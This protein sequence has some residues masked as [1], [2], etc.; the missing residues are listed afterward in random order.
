M[1]IVS[2]HLLTSPENRDLL[3]E[4]SLNAVRA[5][6]ELADCLDFVVAA[7]PIEAG[8][9]NVYEEWKSRAAMERFRSDGP[10]VDLA[11][12]IDHFNITERELDSD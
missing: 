6:R 2:G 4:R 12:L 3:V 5:A 9:V 8:R 1:I 11:G 10:S 7:D